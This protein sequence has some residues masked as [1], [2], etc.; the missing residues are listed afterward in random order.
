MFGGG[1]SI[2][3]VRI[4]GIPIGID[5]SWFIALFLI[6]SLRSDDYEQAV[7]GSSAFLLAV[8]SA[9]LLFLS[10]LLHELGHAVVAIRNGIPILGIELMIFGGVARLGKDS[11]SPGVEFR[12]AAA[13]PLVT[14]VIAV[15]SFGLGAAAEG[16]TGAMTDSLF[17]SGNQSA[18][19]AVLG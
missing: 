6:I 17:L 7:P 3:L 5:W 16:G 13:G 1:G 9:L 18:T 10:I 12:V 2:R 4:F 15:A 8:I 14:L 11:D 19:V